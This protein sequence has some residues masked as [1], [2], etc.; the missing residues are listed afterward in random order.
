MN[1]TYRAEG[2]DPKTIE[3]AGGF[4]LWLPEFTRVNAQELIEIYAGVRTY[5]QTSAEFKHLVDIK[6]LNLQPEVVQGQKVNPGDLMRWII[7]EKDRNRPS[8]STSLDN[9]CGGYA[10]PGK[11]RYTID[12]ADINVVAWGGAIPN[13]GVRENI[14]FPHLCLN[15]ALLADAT[16]IGV[17]AK[18]NAEELTFFTPIPWVRVKNSEKLV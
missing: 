13:S 7:N 1:D 18:Q 5:D 17:K 14:A 8:I 15:A 16:M 4:Q 6:R 10:K 12:C 11:Y 2:R 3:E 9:D